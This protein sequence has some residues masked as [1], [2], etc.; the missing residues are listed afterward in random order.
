VVTGTL[1]DLYE[2]ATAAGIESPALT[3]IGR[4]VELQQKLAWFQGSV[5]SV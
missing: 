4:V 2:K 1:G 3:I 5:D